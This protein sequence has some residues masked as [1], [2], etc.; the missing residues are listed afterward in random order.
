MF[1][2][3]L[4]KL[5][6]ID[7][8]ILEHAIFL[9]GNREQLFKIFEVEVFPGLIGKIAQELIFADPVRILA[10]NLII[11][12]L[13]HAIEGRLILQHALLINLE[14]H[15][16]GRLTDHIARHLLQ[17]RDN[18]Y[19]ELKRFLQVSVVQRYLGRL[20]RVDN[21]VKDFSFLLVTPVA[22]Y[23]SEEHK[24]INR[25]QICL[26]LQVRHRGKLLTRGKRHRALHLEYARHL[27]TVSI[28]AFHA[29]LKR[30]EVLI[31]HPYRP[32]FALY[33]VKVMIVSV[34][35]TVHR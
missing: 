23:A 30:E 31:L 19:H 4:F 6:Q 29:V 1:I 27:H 35:L 14:V 34:T 33:A 25:D 20:L 32:V 11:E 10:E 2:V 12:V 26:P 16:H 17:K 21:S 18:A 28:G 3:S 13:Y 9:Q 22:L 5:R 8:N 15:A 24:R 7:L